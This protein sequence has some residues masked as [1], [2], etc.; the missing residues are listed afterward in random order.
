MKKTICK[1]VAPLSIDEIKRFFSDKSLFFIIDYENSK[2]SDKIFLTYLS[3]LDIPSDIELSKNCDIEKVYKL[4]DSYM[5]LKTISNC[6]FLDMIVA[7]ILLREKNVDIGKLIINPYL[8]E[9]QVQ[10]F[11]KT[12]KDKIQK[13]N[14]FIDSS[15]LYLIYCF[16]ELNKKIQ[17]QNNFP[18]IED[19]NYVGVNVVNM[20]SIP[21]FLEIYFSST[22]DISLSFFSEQFTKYM[23]KGKSFFE[24]YNNKN[25]IFIPLL[26]GLID[27]T[28]PIDVLKSFPELKNK[29]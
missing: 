29:I 14:H 21:N 6:N 11:I 18:V 17:V 19:M 24:F 1:T 28:I 16:E 23:F 15:I 10:E 20:F 13:W 25:N 5:D 27:K 22:K 8:N 3:N 7:H 9:N 26:Q 12:R 2:L 4:I